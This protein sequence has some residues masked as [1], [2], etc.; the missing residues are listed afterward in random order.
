MNN[1]LTQ[2]L[3]SVI[4]IVLFFLISITIFNYLGISFKDDNEQ[5]LRR[6]ITVETFDN[7]HVKASPYIG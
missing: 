4:I 2:I 3:P 7:S 6:V 1:Y 5:V